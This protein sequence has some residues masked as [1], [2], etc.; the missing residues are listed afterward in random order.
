MWATYRIFH[1]LTFISEDSDRKEEKKKLVELM[2]KQSD[3]C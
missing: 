1:I 2:K 3:F